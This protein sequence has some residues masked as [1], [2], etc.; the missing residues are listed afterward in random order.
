ME[1]NIVLFTSRLEKK[2]G[3]WNRNKALFGT[4]PYGKIASDLS[5]SSSQ[6]S[7]LLYGSATEGMYERTLNNINRLIERQSIEKAYEGSQAI[8]NK[9]K[10]THR[11]K[12]Y[13]FS[14]LFFGAGLIT[15]YFLDFSHSVHK[16]LD[17]EKHPLENYFYPESSMFFDSPFIY[18][19]AISENCP[20]SGFEGKWEL[21]ESFKLPLPGMKKPGLY[22]QAKSAG[23]IIRCS[24]LF[25]SY[26][27][28]GHAMMGY[29]HLKSE[30]WIDTKQEPL[31]PQYFN[32]LS[33]EFT[34][35]F[36]QLTFESEPR[37]KKIADLAAFN[38]NMFEVHGDS[39][40]RKAELSGRIAID[41]NKNLAK[42]Y[43]ID[44]GNIVKNILGDLIKASC[45]TAFNPY[46]NPNDLSEGSSR[47]S[48][49]C[50]YTI[51]EENLGLNEG[52]PYTKSYVFKDQVFSD[53]LPC[54]CDSNLIHQ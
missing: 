14:L 21:S 2:Y 44:V 13:F 19:N 32:P 20:C 23:M 51:N 27:D 15:S 43:N 47:I 29:E 46:C 10:H 4:T 8:I 54:K 18:N 49:D 41:I 52:Y 39:I 33:K 16:K 35:S 42:K 24:N 31:V 5:I 11:K 17:Y 30:I 3:T 50:L 28:K 7:K 1:E 45:K 40:T 36:K 26:I 38:V 48:F 34:E 12:I 25:D 53:Y 9:S 22:Y 6:F 37:F